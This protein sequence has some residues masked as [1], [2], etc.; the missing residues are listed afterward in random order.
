MLLNVDSALP[1][2][3]LGPLHLNTFLCSLPLTPF[4]ICGVSEERW[5]LRSAVKTIAACVVIQRGPGTLS[6]GLLAPKSFTHHKKSEL[7]FFFNL[8]LWYVLLSFWLG[9]AAVMLQGGWWCGDF[10]GDNFRG[11]TGGN[12]VEDTLPLAGT[13]AVH[14]RAEPSASSGVAWVCFACR[15][16]RANTHAWDDF[17]NPAN[18]S[19]WDSWNQTRCCFQAFAVSQKV[20]WSQSDES[21]ELLGPGAA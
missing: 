5:I 14:T 11:E 7:A 4:H 17:W 21:F 16:R 19:K 15:L 12:T 18:C 13:D 10:L 20:S 1:I 8:K 9:S 3:V 2:L 6:S